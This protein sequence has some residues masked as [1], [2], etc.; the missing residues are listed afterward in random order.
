MT[1]PS[2]RRTIPWLTDEKLMT[3]SCN[4]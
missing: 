2:A 4:L 3:D 1:E